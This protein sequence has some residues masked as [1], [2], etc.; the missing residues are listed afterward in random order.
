MPVIEGTADTETKP[1]PILDG[2]A[3]LIRRSVATAE[4]LVPGEFVS[5]RSGLLVPGLHSAGQALRARGHAA[6][7]T[8]AQHVYPPF[9]E[10]EQ[11]RIEQ[12]ADEVLHHDHQADP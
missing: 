12:R 5:P 7:D 4:A 3:D 9:V 10:I 1:M 8:D 2:R 11:M 6:R